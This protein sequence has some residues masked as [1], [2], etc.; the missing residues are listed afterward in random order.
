M[1]FY[2]SLALY[3]LFYS[4]SYKFDGLNDISDKLFC[5]DLI[6]TNFIPCINLMYQ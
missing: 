1:D 4:L 2:S 6:H 3:F 5:L